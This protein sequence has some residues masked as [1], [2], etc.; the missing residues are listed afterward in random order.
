MSIKSL[1]KIAAVAAVAGLALTACAD[2]ATSQARAQEETCGVFLGA[3]NKANEAVSRAM[4][5]GD[6]GN[7]RAATV[8]ESAALD[9]R[10]HAFDRSDDVKAPGSNDSIALRTVLQV[11][12]QFFDDMA[13]TIGDDGVSALNTMTPEDVEVNGMSHSEATQALTG[14]CGSYFG[15]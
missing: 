8:V 11:Q 7:A 10:N 12:A 14:Y 1:G 9:I 2:E 15:S 3:N 5:T 6:S 13:T 4:Q